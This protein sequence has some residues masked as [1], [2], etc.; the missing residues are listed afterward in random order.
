MT[1]S[2]VSLAKPNINQ[3][4]V[5]LVE[6]LLADIRSGEVVAVGF[7]AVKSGGVVATSYSHRAEYHQLNSGAAVLA[8]RIASWGNR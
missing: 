8:H 2:I 1:S 7:V 4:A 3:E 6:G 5:D